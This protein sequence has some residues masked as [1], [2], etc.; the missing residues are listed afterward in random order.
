MKRDAYR[1]PYA[2]RDA[3]RAYCRQYFTLKTRY[4]MMDG[5]KGVAYDNDPGGGGISD[6]T[7]RIAEKRANLSRKID[8]IEGACK[9]ASPSLYPYLLLYVADSKTDFHKLQEKGFP[10]NKNHLSLLA[11]KVYWKVSQSI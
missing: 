3:A 6:P 2:E 5:R 1:L 10:L 11:R 4:M 7:M 9:W 8:V